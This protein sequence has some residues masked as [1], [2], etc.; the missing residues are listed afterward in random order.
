MKVEGNDRIVL[1]E[2]INNNVHRN[3]FIFLDLESA[4]LVDVGTTLACVYLDGRE[5]KRASE[6]L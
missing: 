1:D 2:Y 6:W 4:L 3:Y 5:C